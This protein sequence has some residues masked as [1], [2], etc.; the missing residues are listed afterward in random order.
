MVPRQ[1][2]WGRVWANKLNP[3]D[4]ILVFNAGSSTLKF[5]IF[6]DAARVELASGL[7]DWRGESDTATLSCRSQQLGE[8]RDNANVA[9]F[10]E[11]VGWI[12]DSLTEHLCGTSIR[13]VAHRVVHGGVE[14]SGTTLIDEGVCRLLQQV[15]Q[16]APLHNPPA[17][18]TIDAARTALPDTAQVAAFDTAFF[19]NLPPRAFIYPVPYDWHEQYGIRR[20]G[21]HGIS[22]AYCARRAA[23]LLNRQH[24]PALRL[25][26]CHLGNG[27]SATAVRGEHPIATTMGFTPLDGLMMGTRCGGID[28]GIL[29]Y[30]LQQHGVSV[31]QLE[32]SLNRRSGLLGVSGISSDFRQV[33]E[34]AI[35]G[36]ERARLA[37]EMFGDRIRSTVGSLAVTLGGVDALV[38][39]AGIGEHSATIR[40]N[41]CEGL[42]CLGIHLDDQKNRNG[43][44]DSDI[45]TSQSSARILLIRTREELM[46]AR[47]ARRLL[48][49]PPS[50]AP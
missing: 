20:F 12:L 33:E 50:E 41:V 4:G 17:L 3:P 26:I 29:M 36:N 15:G 24:D 7:V 9:E 31:E 22:Y 39:T 28:P 13:V 38:F 42:G 6:D 18:T 19:A 10:S 8:R 11:A 40:S 23:E 2:S 34:A 21:F 48:S 35:A 44:A 30:L 27:C 47:E 16:L 49:S 5:A 32:A 25:V 45:A 14:F 37:I 46:I 43:Q 1:T